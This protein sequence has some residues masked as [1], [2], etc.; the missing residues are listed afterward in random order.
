MGTDLDLVVIGGGPAGERGAAQAAYF[1]KRVAI[2]ER[3]P[4]P[5]GA[6]VHTGTLPSKTLRETALFLSGYRQRHLY[7]LTVD[8]DPEMTVARLLDRKDA[9]RELEV[10]RIHANLDRHG[11]EL[12]RGEARLADPHT[13]EV[14]TAG[15]VRRLRSD[16]VLIATGSS[17]HHPPGIPYDDPDVHDADGILRIDRLP[18]SMA[19]I[20]GGVIGCEYACMFA[21]LGVE[22]HLIDPRPGLLPF[23]D[24]E[25]GERLAA[26]M[27]GL[28]V[29]MHLECEHERVERG[30]DGLACT[31]GSGEVLIVDTVMVAAGRQGNTADLGL[32]AIGV[33]VDARGYVEVDD[34]FRTAVP[35]VYAAGDVVGFPSLASVSMEQARVAVCHA[36]GFTYKRQVSELL[37]Y[38]VYTI[39]EVSCV[40]LGEDEA[41]RR[42]LD[43][44][45]G[46]SFFRDN[47]RGQI[48][49]DRDGMVKLVF[50]RT[51][52]RLIGCHCIGE[53]AS[54]L[55]HVGQAVIVLDGTVE[56]FIEMVFNHPTLG[57][58]FKYAAYDALAKLGPA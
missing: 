30:P 40:G 46:R 1:G 38:G 42:G 19:L 55:V 15:G 53:R 17:P 25:M 50:D 43:V 47:V 48:V 5:G 52:R 28:G 9:V 41:A 6:A 56:T 13:V 26:A 44:V 12:V 20:G 37:P 32:A 21:A 45:A 24:R 4:E 57:E 39:P 18:T 51:T 31:L 10:Q 11:I 23:L 22:V 58:T 36:F 49:G 54:E 33:G 8:V 34:D 29:R 3:Q 14:A 35:N 2:V 16:V 7:G 27:E